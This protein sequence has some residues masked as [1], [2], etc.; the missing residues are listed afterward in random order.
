MHRSSAVLQDVNRSRIRDIHRRARRLSARRSATC[1][2]VVFIWSETDHT[3]IHRKFTA[4]NDEHD[5]AYDQGERDSGRVRHVF[6]NAQ[7]SLRLKTATQ[8][9]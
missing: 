2:S 7:K 3:E 5:V 1:T 8:T 9:A 4:Y 6:G